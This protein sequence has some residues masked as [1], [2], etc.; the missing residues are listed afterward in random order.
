VA[1]VVVRVVVVLIVRI[2]RCADVALI[3]IQPTSRW[4]AVPT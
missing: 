2:A 4:C 1:E 3:R